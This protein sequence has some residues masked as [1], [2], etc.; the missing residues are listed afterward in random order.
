MRKRAP[1]ACVL[2][3][4]VLASC[5]QN[6]D[7]P[8]ARQQPAG[9][10]APEQAPDV[11]TLGRFYSQRP[12]WVPCPDRTDFDCTTVKVPLDY[13][14]PGG[15][16]LELALARSHA[17]EPARRIGSLLL[18][19]GGPGV[20]GLGWLYGK[21]AEAKLGIRFDLVSFDPRGVG[22]SHPVT[23]LDDRGLDAFYA[24]DFAPITPDGRRRAVEA[25]Q[26]YAQA[27]RARS[28]KL[29][30]H[31]G[32]ENTARDVDVIRA[33]LG[34]A[35]LNAFASSY[36]TRIA[37]FYARQYPDK[38]GRMV[39]DSVDNP[40]S[41]LPATNGKDG[42]SPSPADGANDA[43]ETALRSMVE[44]CTAGTDCALGSDPATGMKKLDELLTSL[45]VRPLPLSDGRTLGPTLATLA[46]L[47]AAYSTD[48]W[49][50]LAAG[51]K[52]ALRDGRGDELAELA[53]EFTG[54]ADG[55]YDPTQTAKAAIDNLVGDPDEY[56]RLREAPD[57][58]PRT[59]ESMADHASKGSPHFARVWTYATGASLFWPVPPT[60]RPGPV[61]PA[62][63]PPLLLLNNTRDPA[64]TLT[65]AEQVS[66]RLPG[67]T[68]ITH[69][70]DG[71][72]VY[73]RNP[74]VDRAVEDYLHEGTVPRP[75]RCSGP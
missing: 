21:T 25:A 50:R 66:R 28:G 46:M 8:G 15:D 36:G 5:A 12:S 59:L 41:D 17:A 23:C 37:Q 30:P 68:L 1:A 72:N 18:I 51:W 57:R 52:Q 67:S 55:R 43:M 62:G 33:A 34:E 38:V 39:L 58:I 54:R 42:E 65:D 40:S 19:P 49:P 35:A 74:C 11:G 64:T 61:E 69:D 56:R 45:R 27:C 44:A 14:R 7:A 26:T 6:H 9:T 24:T 48:S 4:A 63:I 32:T 2:A 22:L 31:V 10:L 3:L 16:T 75:E 20:S 70:A 47:Q 13:T 71:H 73:G 53:D 29:L 60:W